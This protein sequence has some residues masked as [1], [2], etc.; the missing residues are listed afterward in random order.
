M[1][2]LDSIIQQALE[3]ALAALAARARDMVLEAAEQA[4]AARVKALLEEA[5]L[6]APAQAPAQAARAKAAQAQALEAQATPA[7]ETL[8]K[9]KAR[10]RVKAQATPVLAQEDD[11]KAILE[12][13]Q[14]ALGKYAGIHT[15]RGKPLPEVLYRRVRK[16]LEHA[17][18]LG[19][20]D[21][22]A[23][24]RSALAVI[25]ANPM[26]VAMGSWQALASRLGLPVPV[27]QAQGE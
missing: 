3:E 10:K 7:L 27:A 5:G 19:R 21:L 24:A 22:P 14:A 20:Q 23:L 13:A 12:A 9:A 6:E 15:P 1:T 17:A 2:R 25:A 11:L 16:T 4:L 26:G 8:A 18:S